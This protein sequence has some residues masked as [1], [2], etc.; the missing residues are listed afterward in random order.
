MAFEYLV[1]DHLLSARPDRVVATL[2]QIRKFGYAGTPRLYQEAY[3]MDCCRAGRLGE[4]A[5][6]AEIDP[7]LTKVYEEMN[8]AYRDHGHDPAATLD[9]I[10]NRHGNTYFAYYMRY[11]IDARVAD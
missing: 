3:L 1:A 2:P 11:L 4:G 7:N 5:A 9:A 8:A 10:R 6:P